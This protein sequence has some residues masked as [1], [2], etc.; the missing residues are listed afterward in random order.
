LL[1]RD[2]KQ[3]IFTA[4]PSEFMEPFLPLAIV[5]FAIF[6]TIAIGALS[7]APWVPTKK[8]DRDTVARGINL[9][10]G[11][12]VYDLGCG[13]GSMLFSLVDVHPDIRAVGYEIAFPPLAWG[14]F[15]KWRGGSKYKNVSMY[16]RDFW[17]KDVSDADAVFMF[18]MSPAYARMLPKLTRELRDEAI[19]I[20]E[21][22]PFEGISYDQKL[23]GDGKNL[24]MFVYSGAKLRAAQTNQ[25]TSA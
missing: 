4:L 19:V 18:L 11:A 10:P 22:W 8:R 23:G 5:T 17:A 24:P 12:K 16:W 3:R 2:P 15:R 6:S 25:K 7:A 14:W 21:C 20:L 13:D 9:R 1:H